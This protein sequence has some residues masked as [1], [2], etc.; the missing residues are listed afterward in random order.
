MDHEF[1]W[2]SN[3]GAECAKCGDGITAHAEAPITF[4]GISII[5]SCGCTPLAGCQPKGKDGKRCIVTQEIV[6]EL[7]GGGDE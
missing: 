6:S 7:D 3:F 1:V 5:W 4:Q 2:D